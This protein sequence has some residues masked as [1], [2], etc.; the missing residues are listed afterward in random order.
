MHNHAELLSD[1]MQVGLGVYYLLVTLMN[2]GFAW[3]F[4]RKKDT[5]MAG[6]W[7]AVAGVFLLHAVLYFLPFG[8]YLLLPEFIRVT[9]DG[10]MNAVSYFVLSVVAFVLLLRFRKQ[11]TEPVVAWSI[12]NVV[13]LF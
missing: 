6:I 13:L 7:A 8:K 3:P 11:L 2:L 1:S 9:V 5:R 4:Y 12:L 10:M